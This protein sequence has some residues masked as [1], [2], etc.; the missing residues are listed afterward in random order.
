[1]KNDLDYPIEI[2]VLITRI[3][4]R[5]P[6]YITFEY[7]KNEYIAFAPDYNSDRLPWKG[8]KQNQ[9]SSVYFEALYSP[10]NM[11]REKTSLRK[12]EQTN[13]NAN[14]D[15]SAWGEITRKF[16]K[17]ENYAQPSFV[18]DCG[19]PIA[20]WEPISKDYQTGDYVHVPFLRLDI[21][22]VGEQTLAVLR[23]D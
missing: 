14:S 22:R 12:L 6:A 2:E 23:K 18:L 9:I 20:F 21:H 17:A 11:R 1:M 3:T 10:K 8:I 7:N 5:G 13:K 4:G 16:E 15:S 19:I